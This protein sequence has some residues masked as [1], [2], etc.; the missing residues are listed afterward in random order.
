MPTSNQG[1]ISDQVVRELYL[2][3]ELRSSLKLIKIGFGELQKINMDNNFYHLPLQLLS[4]GIERFL[5]CYLCLGFHEKNGHFPNFE[6]LKGF[7]GSTGHSIMDL[8][9]EVLDNFYFIRHEK[10]TLL[11]DDQLFIRNDERLNKLLDLLSEFGKFARYHNLD[12]VSAKKK[13]SRDIE[14]E[15]K[16]FE[17]KL[18]KENQSVFRKF[19]NPDIKYGNEVYQYINSIIIALLERYMRALARQFTFVNLGKLAKRFSV[20][21]YFLLKIKDE[22]LGK[23]VY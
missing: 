23:N 3:Q 19:F 2:L 17:T 8:T 10:D 15:W 21:I 20:D 5:K 22:N 4:S 1:K 13:P 16:D 6:E 7:G 14:K 12:I 18:L 9:R 11:G